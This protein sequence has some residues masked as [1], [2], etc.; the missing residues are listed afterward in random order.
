MSS[1][2]RTHDLPFLCWA[3]PAI[4]VEGILRAPMVRGSGSFEAADPLVPMLA[5]PGAAAGGAALLVIVGIL[6]A[7]DNG[8]RLLAMLLPAAVV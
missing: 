7:P 6:G 1:P 2:L 3:G 4:E 5:V 8:T